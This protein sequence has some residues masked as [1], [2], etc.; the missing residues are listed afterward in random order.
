MIYRI[1]ADIV[2][3][4]HFAFVIFSVFGG[5][6]AFW[7]R[8]AVWVHVPAVLWAAAVNLSSRVCPLTP[9]ENRLRLLAGQ[10]GYEGGFVEHY[11]IPLVYPGGMTRSWEIAAGVSVLA[12]NCVVYLLLILSWRRR[13]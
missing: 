5:L 11:I 13:G 3:L 2:L 8:R 6:F 7:K 1:S 10:A 9:L 4:F 12:W